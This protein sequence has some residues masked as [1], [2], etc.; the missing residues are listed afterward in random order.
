MAADEL[1]GL[2][3]SPDWAP[4]LSDVCSA[5]AGDSELAFHEAEGE[6]YAADLQL[7]LAKEYRGIRES[8][9]RF[10][11]RFTHA[12]TV[13]F[14]RLLAAGITD[15]RPPTDPCGECD[16]GDYECDDCTAF[17]EW[18]SIDWTEY[19]TWLTA[20]SSGRDLARAR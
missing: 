20:R 9:R 8:G 4:D 10:R 3:E 6:D 18:E 5:E 7:D 17:R 13:T 12:G 11:R 1:S 2:D 16:D 14:S 19:E 15:E